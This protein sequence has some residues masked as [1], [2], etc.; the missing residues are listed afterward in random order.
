MRGRNFLCMSLLTLLT[1]AAQAV[2]REDQAMPKAS[3]SF[4]LYHDYLIV[5]QGSAGPLKGL[6]FLVDTGASPTILDRRLAQKLGLDE[7]PASIIFVNGSVPAGQAIVPNLEFGPTRR[8]NLPILV[9]DLSFF[10][11]ALPVHIDAVIGLDVLGQSAFEIDYTSWQIHF[12]S[13]RPLAN[14]LPLR[15]EAGLPIIDAEL[16]HLAV[17]LLMDTG[18]SSLLLFEPRTS[19]PV[20]PQKISAV[21]GSSSS[22]G[23]FQGKQVWLRSLRLGG[24]EFG[25]EPAFMVRS[26][27][28]QD[29]NFDRNFDGLIS[30][31]GLG[32]TKVAIDVGRGV[33]AF[34]R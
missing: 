14:S 5:A 24:K 21:A 32:M 27:G 9:E 20:L 19:G 18:A 1:V 33:L 3:V 23:E 7:L 26:P 11:R 16:N 31:A 13:F 4:H 34:N 15:I 12:G 30:P 29:R 6:N 28:N 22:I 2:A 8:H 17:R 25:R 10:E